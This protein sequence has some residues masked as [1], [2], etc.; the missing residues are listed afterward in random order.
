MVSFVYYN[1]RIATG[2]YIIESVTM[3][4]LIKDQL[5]GSGACNFSAVRFMI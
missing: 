1:M 5:Y 2:F 3:L 4:L